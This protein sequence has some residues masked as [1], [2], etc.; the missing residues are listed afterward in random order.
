MDRTLIE[1]AIKAEGGLSRRLFLQYTTALASLPLFQEQVFGQV[2]KMTFESDP[3]SLGVASGDPDSKSVVL[4]TKLAPKPLLPDG[5]MPTQPVSVLWEIAEDDRMKKVVAKGEAI[6]TPQL[7]HSVHVIPTGLK[8]DRWYWYRFHCGDAS[9]IIGR[10]RTMPEKAATPNK[11]RFAFASCQHYEQGLYT[12]YEQMAKD[13]LDLVFHLGDYIYEY[14]H[15]PK[16]KTVRKHSGP[17][18]RKIQ[19]LADYRERHAQ[20]RADPLLNGMHALCPWFVTWDDHEFDNNYANDIQEEQRGDKKQADPV[21]FLVQRAAAYQAYYEM[22]PLRPRALPTG[23][24]ML[25]YRSASFGNLADFFVLDTRQY[26]TDQPNKDGLKPLNEEALKKTNSLLGRKQRNWLD[27]G[28]LRST[29]TWNVLAQQVMMGMVHLK[30][31]TREGFSMDQWPGAAHERMELMK[32]ISDRKVPNPVV[33]TGD[34]H[35]NWVN[36]LRVDDRQHDAP[37]VATEFVATSI[38]SGGNGLKEIPLVDQFLK[39]NPCVQFLNM[40]RGYVRCVVTP[41][42]WTSDY[43]VAEDVLKPNG[44]VV[45]RASFVVEAGM[46]GAKKA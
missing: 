6:A 24:D 32:F 4:W 22:M 21:D 12:A 23:P 1:Q 19:T 27:A 13:E 26:R 39:D 43:V 42:T 17:K 35:S 34:I 28:L 3:F 14:P 46:P 31:G 20:Y 25:L 33:L 11:L 37:V 30:S 18:D 10:T 41:E 15:N 16:A 36:N 40:Q 38:S 29:S 9:S 5:G 2:R 45:T 7:G 8:P 44:N